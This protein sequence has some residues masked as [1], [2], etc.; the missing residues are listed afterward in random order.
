MNKKHFLFSLGFTTLAT[1]AGVVTENTLRKKDKPLESYGQKV[2]VFGKYISTEIIGDA[3]HV[4]VL[5][6]GACETSPIL[7]Y[8]ALAKELAKEF[9]VVTIEPFGYGAS[10]STNHTRSLENLSEELHQTMKKLGYPKYS[11]CLHSAAGIIGMAEAI[12]YPEEIESI[13]C[14]DTT[15][16][17]LTDYTSSRFLE[18]A[19]GRVLKGCNKLG[20]SRLLHKTNKLTP[21]VNGYTF[22]DK[23]KE[24]YFKCTLQNG[25]SKNMEEELNELDTNLRSML[26]KQYPESI[27]VYSFVSSSTDKLLTKFGAPAGKWIEAHQT[28]SSNPK[29]VVK[30][31]E[32]HHYLHHENPEGI[33]SEY[34]EWFKNLK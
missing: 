6:P 27:P 8:R 21:K 24:D 17:E 18:K 14:I 34:I 12:K 1:V 31:V 13:L 30:V 33:A 25:F 23:E 3:K 9:T 16:A 5:Y 19:S 20:I 7:S 2:R 4:I 22:S 26:N 11:L 10:D 28:V 15:I 32:G 29:S